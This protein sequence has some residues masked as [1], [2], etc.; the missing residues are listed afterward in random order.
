[1]ARGY[2]IIRYAQKFKSQVARLQTDLWSTDMK[3]TPRTSSGNTRE[4]H[5]P[6][7]H[8]SIWHST[9]I[10]LWGAA[11]CSVRRGRSVA[12]DSRCRAPASGRDAGPPKSGALHLDHGVS[13]EDLAQAGFRYVFNLSGGSP[14]THLASLGLGWKGIGPLET[15]RRSPRQQVA[16]AAVRDLAKS[17]GPLARGYRWIKKRVGPLMGP[18]GSGFEDFDTAARRRPRTGLRVERLPKPREM[19][20]LVNRTTTDGRIRNATI[21]TGSDAA[22]EAHYAYSNSIS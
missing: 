4:I 15:M 10:G 2:R 20:A 17:I 7:V 1:M 21:P 12:S 3:G 13:L 11:A 5:T 6:I 18:R 16:S 19:A 14:V 9:A 22:A 8:S